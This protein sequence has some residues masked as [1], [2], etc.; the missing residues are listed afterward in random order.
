[1]TYSVIAECQ[2]YLE[3]SPELNYDDISE[4][5]NEAVEL[6]NDLIYRINHIQDTTENRA[7]IKKE[8]KN[9][10]NIL[11]DKSIDYIERLNSLF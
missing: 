8:Y 5:I 6:R 3:F 2:N 7:Q 1:M 11:Y 4:I 10:T 9:M